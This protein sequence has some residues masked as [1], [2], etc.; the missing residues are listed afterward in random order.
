MC[1]ISFITSY[2]QYAFLY[3]HYCVHSLFR[4]HF[5]SFHIHTHN[6]NK[7]NVTRNAVI[8]LC[9]IHIISSLCRIHI[10]SFCIH[11]TAH[12]PPHLYAPYFVYTLLLS[13]HT[14]QLIPTICI[15]ITSY[16]HCFFLYTQYCS[17][18]PPFVCTLLRIHITSFCTH[19][20]AHIHHLYAHFSNTHCFFPYTQYCSYH[21]PSVRTLF[22]THIAAF[23]IHNT[24]HNPPHSYAHSF[25]YTLLLSV[26]TLQLIPPISYAHSFLPYT[27]QV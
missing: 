1:S 14:F 26:Y 19:N 13:V 15:H 9:H 22:G 5:M 10:T 16:T 21:P 8:S 12:T 2:I 4:T 20:T 7:L 17:Y 6:N 25:I 24:A 27:L 23:F 11:N 18:P 3:P